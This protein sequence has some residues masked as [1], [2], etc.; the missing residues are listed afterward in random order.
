MCIHSLTFNGNN[1]YVKSVKVRVKQDF[2]VGDKLRYI[3]LWAVE[4]KDTL[5]QDVIVGKMHDSSTT[6]FT[7]KEDK[8]F[9]KYVEIFVNRK[10]DRETYFLIGHG[11]SVTYVKQVSSDDENIVY[12]HKDTVPEVDATGLVT[13]SKRY[14]VQY[15]LVGENMNLAL[16]LEK[17]SNSAGSFVSSVNTIKPNDKGDVT[18]APTN[19]P[20]LLSVKCKIHPVSHYE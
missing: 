19:I 2:T 7:V 17:I 20:G 15:G 18:I 4:K 6:W 9:G 14:L 11:N 12:A 13:D 8:D 10:F 16:E 5:A 1:G 3:D